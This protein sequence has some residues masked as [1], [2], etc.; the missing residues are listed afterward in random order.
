MMRP[1][2]L[3]DRLQPAAASIVGRRH[4]LHGLIR[5]AGR[6]AA[7]ALDR[8]PPFAEISESLET[9]LRL[10][11]AYAQ[12]RYRKIP[13]RSILAL[14]AGLIYLVTPFDAV[15]D[16]LVTIGFMDDLAVLSLVMRQISHDLEAF[17]AWEAAPDTA[18]R[19]KPLQLP[20]IVE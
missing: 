2:G 13:Y 4:R 20:H 16:I 3:L 9:A 5:A 8:Y 19:A 17:R 18:A 14:T 15:P 11:K 1:K 10:L 12:G 6:T 7:R